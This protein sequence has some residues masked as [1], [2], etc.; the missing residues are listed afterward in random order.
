MHD[1]Y[2]DEKKG[3]LFKAFKH[4]KCRGVYNLGKNQEALSDEEY[5]GKLT[6]HGKSP[7]HL[8]FHIWLSFSFS[9]FVL[10][11]TLKYIQIRN[12]VEILASL[13]LFLVMTILM[14]KEAKHYYEKNNRYT[15]RIISI[16]SLLLI[17]NVFFYWGFCKATILFLS[18]FCL[19]L[20]L[21]VLY[22]KF[23]TL[24]YVT[25]VSF[26]WLCV[27]THRLWLECVLAL[28]CWAVIKTV[29]NYLNVIPQEKFKLHRLHA[30]I[31]DP[32]ITLQIVCLLL[33]PSIIFSN[34]VLFPY[35]LGTWGI[36]LW[37]VI[38]NQVYLKIVKFASET[39]KR[40]SAEM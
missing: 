29:R 38:F 7:F 39:N 11:Y 18:W 23:K 15:N 30:N 19:F 25:I 6:E 12:N 31:W 36:I 4:S 21:C 27:I 13:G 17:S 40:Y 37:T 5:M 26:S 24:N 35:F 9:L 22:T 28:I 1:V 10:I 34:K 3:F 2:R 33:F 16:F 8:I 32:L 14:H 20:E